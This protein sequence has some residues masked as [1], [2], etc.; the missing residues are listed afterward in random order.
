M[1]LLCAILVIACSENDADPEPTATRV[2]GTEQAPTPELSAPP[3]ENGYAL[4]P[5]VPSATY[6]QMLGLAVVPG[7]DDQAILITQ[8][9]ELRQVS[10]TSREDPL[11]F[12]DVSQ[13]LISDPGREEGLL[14]IVFSPEYES[15]SS[16]YLYYSA[17][18]PRRL[19]L[20][21]F[22]VANGTLDMQSEQVLLEIDDPFANHNGGQLAFGP[23]GM[24]YLGPGDGGS[25]ND[26]LENGQDLSDLLGSILRIDVSGG[27]ASYEI[28]PDNPFVDTP[29]ALPEIYAYGLRNPWRFSFDRETGDLWLGDV[30][31]DR[32][33]EVNRIEAGGNYGWSI[34][35]GFE[36]F[37]AQDCD[38]IGLIPPRATYG[39]DGGCSVT[40]GYVY[41][42]EAMPELQGYY[43]YADFCTGNTWAVDSESDLSAPILISASGARVS[44]F[45]ELP[46]GELLLLTYDQAIYRLVRAP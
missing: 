6:P 39:R 29:G 16:L 45:T 37:Q 14:G 41:R 3:R 10:L 30:G 12:G 34:M 35:E 23:D 46:D 44:S 2:A 27:A 28:P 15:D 40:G 17:G 19:V 20:S 32:F 31:Q 1:L 33:E 11:F 38:R 21:R 43:I 4:E 25:A 24:L 22:L 26:P 36:C 5:A 9:G 18:E 13:L 42:G 8:T 7:S